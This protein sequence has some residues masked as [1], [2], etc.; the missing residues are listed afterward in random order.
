MVQTFEKKGKFRKFFQA[1]LSKFF[2]TKFDFPDLFFVDLT[3]VKKKQ[4]EFFYMNSYS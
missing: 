3:I 4:V 2:K 1:K